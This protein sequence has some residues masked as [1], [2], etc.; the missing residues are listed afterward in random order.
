MKIDRLT[1]TH[2]HISVVYFY[3]CDNCPSRID[4]S[5]AA[6]EYRRRGG[7]GEHDGRQD[8]QLVVHVPALIHIPS[9]EGHLLYDDFQNLRLT[10]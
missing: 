3:L 2:T 10:I 5:Q 1:H 6:F 4:V 9:L 8:R 7:H